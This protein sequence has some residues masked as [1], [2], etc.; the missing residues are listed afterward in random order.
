MGNVINFFLSVMS[1]LIK[2][3]IK[4]KFFMWLH[5]VK[6]KNFFLLLML[7]MIGMCDTPSSSLVWQATYYQSIPNQKEISP[8]YCKQHEP[9]TFIGVVQDQLAI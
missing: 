6:L 3:S 4:G 9:G 8:S 1:I 5:N 7:P 2:I